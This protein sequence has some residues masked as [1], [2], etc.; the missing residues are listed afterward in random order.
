MCRFVSRHA[1]SPRQRP[2]YA[3]KPTQALFTATS[4]V[5]SGRRTYPWPRC[6]SSCASCLANPPMGMSASASATVA[7]CTTCCSTPRRR[8]TTGRRGGCS[9]RG[10]GGCCRAP[11]DLLFGTTELPNAYSSTST[12]S[13]EHWPHSIPGLPRDKART[14]RV[15]HSHIEKGVVRHMDG[16]A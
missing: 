9:Q 3:A 15:V 4:V 2:V 8:P 6:T 5:I 10:G 11:W 1:S 12:G 14:T 7:P 13:A 16:A